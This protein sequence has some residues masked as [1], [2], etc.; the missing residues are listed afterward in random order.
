MLACSNSEDSE[1]T[2]KA[3]QPLETAAVDYPKAAANGNT[4]SPYGQLE[5]DE[6]KASSHHRIDIEPVVKLD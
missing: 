2:D 3:D 5:G 6:G 1:A 4:I